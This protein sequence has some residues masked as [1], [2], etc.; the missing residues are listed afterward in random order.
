MVCGSPFT[1]TVSAARIASPYSTMQYR[2]RPWKLAMISSGFVYPWPR[3]TCMLLLAA[4]AQAVR[5]ASE[6]AS[7][8]LMNSCP[9]SII[10]L[11]RYLFI[12][13]FSHWRL[14][15]AREQDAGVE[16]EQAVVPAGAVSE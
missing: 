14:H 7:P 1:L 11:L 15:T 4:A 2:S 5:A 3:K 6:D 12:R 16:D 10:M 9:A 8:G 13:S